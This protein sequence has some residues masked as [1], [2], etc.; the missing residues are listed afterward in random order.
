MKEY[1]TGMTW[2][3]G[4][5]WQHG[6][7]WLSDTQGGKLWTDHDGT[8][9]GIP[10]DAVPNGLWFL[11]DGRLAGAM[12]YERR[13]G[14]WTGER[15]D[16]YAD[17]SAVATG[18]LGDMTGDPY[19]NLYVDDIGFAAHAGEPVRP[20]RVLRVAADGT[21]GVAAED[22][23][24]PNGLAFVDDGRTLV[25]A[26]TT[27]QRLTAFTVAADGALTGRRTYADLARLVGED[28]RP[29]GI[30]AVPDGVWVA[31]TTGHAVALV[32]ENE[33]VTSVGTGT[34]L[35][36]ACCGDGGDRLFVT[37]ADTG[38]RPLGEAMAHKAVRTTVALLDVTKAGDAL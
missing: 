21:V 11:P 18:P 10:L 24:F 8:W 31:T 16:T 34:L 4:P 28:A 2:G 23:E 20:G 9:R 29:D 33:L 15:F 19:G 35:P 3:E 14:V 27:R 1:A 6:A 12:M 5:R 26:E 38:G 22:I 36:I 32:R 30:W 37:L 13:I 17:L 7:L 25:V